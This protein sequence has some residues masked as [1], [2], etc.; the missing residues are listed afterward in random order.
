MQDSGQFFGLLV[1]CSP[2]IFACE[3]RCH[4]SVDSC[5]FSHACIDRVSVHCCVEEKR[6]FFDEFV[7]GDLWVQSFDEGGCGADE[8]ELDGLSDF[9]PINLVGEVA[10]ISIDLKVVHTGTMEKDVDEV[11]D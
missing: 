11:F 10:Q 5:A 1:L 8:V 9:I 2:R 7:F 3:P 6:C 4:S